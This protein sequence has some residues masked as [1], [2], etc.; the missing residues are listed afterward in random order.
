MDSYKKVCAFSHD[1]ECFSTTATTEKDILK[2]QSCMFP[3]IVTL[4]NVMVGL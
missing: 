4:G 1:A 2:T 3:Y